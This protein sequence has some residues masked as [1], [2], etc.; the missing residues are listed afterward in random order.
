MATVNWCLG[1]IDTLHCIYMEQARI[2]LDP[3][4]RYPHVHG[5]RRLSCGWILDRW[6]LG[7]H[8]ES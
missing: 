2:A 7:S 4:S 8:C 6:N 3:N 5:K 1:V